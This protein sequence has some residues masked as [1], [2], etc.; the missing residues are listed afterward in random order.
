MFTVLVSSGTAVERDQEHISKVIKALTDFHGLLDKNR[1]IIPKASSRSTA[2][3][4]G[5]S[6]KPTLGS[7]AT[8]GQRKPRARKSRQ[9]PTARE[10]A[11]EGQ[12]F[13]DIEEGVDVLYEVLEVVFSE[14]H[15]QLVVTYFE[16]EEAGG[17][18]LT[19]EDLLKDSEH[20]IIECSTVAEVTAWIKD[21]QRKKKRV[22]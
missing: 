14:V 17:F 11:M 3:G 7:P 13:E 12:L 19:R 21:Y 20:E 4:S 15:G 16:V 2:S 9:T 8:R 18:D 5:T 1:M 10:T 22:L 6:K